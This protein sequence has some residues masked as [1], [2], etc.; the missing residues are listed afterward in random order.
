MYEYVQWQRGL[1]DSADVQRRGEISEGFDKTFEEM[2][3]EE[4]IPKVENRN[5][6][7]DVGIQAEREILRIAIEFGDPESGKILPLRKAH[8][9]YKVRQSAGVT[10]QPPGAAAPISGGEG[11][12]ASK[13]GL[14]YFKDVHGKKSDE[15]VQEALDRGEV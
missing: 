12:A 4:L 9:I 7:K 8:E 14:D 6:N 11:G 2:R 5:D 15:I 10:P 1:E 13:P 3:T